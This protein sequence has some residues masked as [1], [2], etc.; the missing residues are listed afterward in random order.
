MT[1]TTV[2]WEQ[3]TQQRGVELIANRRAGCTRGDLKYEEACSLL[4]LVTLADC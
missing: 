2:P 3:T 1:V 4:G